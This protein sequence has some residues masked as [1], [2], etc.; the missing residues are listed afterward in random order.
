M[1]RLIQNKKRFDLLTLLRTPITK[2]SKATP[3]IISRLIQKHENWPPQPYCACAHVRFHHAH[4]NG[5]GQW[6]P[7]SQK[8]KRKPPYSSSSRLMSSI[9]W[10]LNH[11]WPCLQVS[12]WNFCIWSNNWWATGPCTQG[13]HSERS[14][15]ARTADLGFQ[16]RCLW[17]TIDITSRSPL[18]FFYRSVHVVIDACARA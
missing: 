7:K 12:L 15:R 16:F 6:R 18:G 2:F 5:N 8:F 4:G 11:F 1:L 14:A 3:L 10:F 9:F 13:A 17:V